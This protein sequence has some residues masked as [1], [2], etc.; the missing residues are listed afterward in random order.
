M[1]KALF[2]FRQKIILGGETVELIQKN[3][4][5]HELFSNVLYIEL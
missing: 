4:S 3:C 2:V 1:S 5:N